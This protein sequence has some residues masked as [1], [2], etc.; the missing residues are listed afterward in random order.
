[1]SEERLETQNLARWV[2]S[3]EPRRWVDSH[4]RQWN[5]D[6]WLALLSVL[7]NSSYWP[8][9]PD[10][11]GLTLEELKRTPEPPLPSREPV[12]DK[13][14]SGRDTAIRGICPSCGA[15]LKQRRAGSFSSCPICGRNYCPACGGGVWFRRTGREGQ[16]ASVWIFNE[17]QN[18]N[19]KY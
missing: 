16:F 17:C 18:C 2:A 4:H 6:D 1:M 15:E 7:L 19:R 12:Q 3:G 10:S 5:H 14:S 13:A 8:M 9:E 11:V